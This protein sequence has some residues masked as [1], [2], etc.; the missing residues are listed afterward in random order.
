MVSVWATKV[1]EGGSSKALSSLSKDMAVVRGSSVQN[2]DHTRAEHG[3][4]LRGS[5]ATLQDVR[6]VSHRY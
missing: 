6:L 3:D 2:E 1:H 4:T 5:K